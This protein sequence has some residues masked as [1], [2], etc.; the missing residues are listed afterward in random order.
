MCAHTNGEFTY[1][2]LD[3]AELK[4]RIPQVSDT[5][6]GASYSPQ[7]GHVNPLYLLRALHQ[8]MQNLGCRY[9][10]DQPVVSTQQRVMDTSLSTVPG[11][12]TSVSASYS[13]PASPISVWPEISV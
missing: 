12:V 11:N 1:Q 9:I 10:P 8:R 6:L 2:M 13:A 3:N 5:V 7:D 4:E